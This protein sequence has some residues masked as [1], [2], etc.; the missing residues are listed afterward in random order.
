MAIAVG[1]ALLEWKTDGGE[2]Y[3]GEETEALG[4]N[5]VDGTCDRCGTMF[6]GCDGGLRR[7]R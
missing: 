7:N 6:L 3:V 2:S 5:M 1:R 4:H